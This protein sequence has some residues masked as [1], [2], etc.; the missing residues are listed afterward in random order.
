MITLTLPELS[1]R[2]MLPLLLV[3]GY[4]A[5]G[6]YYLQHYFIPDANL[7]LG[8]VL[9]P[10]LML[11]RK[12][13]YSYRYLLPTLVCLGFSAFI[14]LTSLVY[15]TL[16]FGMLLMVESTIGKVSY[17][18]PFLLL[19]LSTIF[20]YFSNFIGFPIRLWLSKIAGEILLQVG[21][22]V[23]VSGNLISLN[24]E[25]FSVD[26]A[27]AGLRMIATSF[28]LTLFILAFYQRKTRKE[29]SFGF[30][31]AL[32]LL[33]LLLNIGAN[34][35]R[36]VLL[37]LFKIP[38]ENLFHD[39]VGMACL[40]LYVVLP[41]LF[42]TGKFFRNGTQNAEKSMAVFPPKSTSIALSFIVLSATVLVGLKTE[43]IK[44]AAVS[45][46][47]TLALAGYQKQILTDNITK[48]ENEEFL[49]YVK[50]VSF[51]AAEHS[52]MVCWTGSGYNFKSINVEQLNGR[53][54][55]TGVLQKGTDKLYTAWWFDK[56]NCKTINQWE[57][58]WQAAKTNQ[59][60]NLINVSAS[61]PGALQIK[62]KELLSK[63]LF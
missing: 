34:L 43:K 27:C 62:T 9:A 24:G 33:T 42:I 58:R 37:V 55:Y 38:P 12:G 48:F 44:A 22:Q 15:L 1:V 6:A 2:R 61:T 21:Q 30:V 8:L 26:P 52:P 19:I 50:P 36:I 46:E 35:L 18:I 16:I 59:A 32:L 4:L 31:A 40:V 39:L 5:F 63:P 60:F 45:Q 29:I 56:G 11:I 41:L 28:I 54:I 57:W 53:E 25:A 10:Y 7:Y 20:N 17:F 49:I 3:A 13:A 51:Y 23:E 47:N 14:P